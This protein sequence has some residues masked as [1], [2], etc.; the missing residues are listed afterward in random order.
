MLLAE[1]EPLSQEVVALL[2]VDAG[3]CPVLVAN[4]QVALERARDGGYDLISM[5]VQMPDMDGL[6]AT[7]AIRRL[8]GMAD[9]PILAMTA[10]AFDE[11]RDRCL[12]AGMSDHIGKPVLPETFYR[13]LL[14]W[15]RVRRGS[16]GAKP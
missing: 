9:V 2:L 3:L 14:R 13:S 6:D 1:D 4:G 16:D 12:A 8:P 7:R 5:D 11:D 10:N 15:L